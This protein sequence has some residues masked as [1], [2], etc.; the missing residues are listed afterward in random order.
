MALANPEKLKRH[1]INWHRCKYNDV[2][3]NKDQRRRKTG[4]PYF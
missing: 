1:L 3:K 2:F 4:R